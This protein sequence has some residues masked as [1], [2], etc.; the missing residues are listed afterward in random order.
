MKNYI[1][2]IMFVILFQGCATW[3]GLVQDSKNAWE[4]TKELSGYAYDSTKKAINDMS[5]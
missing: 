3:S 5:E 4:M 2:L 1:F